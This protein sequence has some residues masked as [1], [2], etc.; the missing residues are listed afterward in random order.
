MFNFRL[1]ANVPVQTPALGRS[2]TS[3]QSAQKPWNDVDRR[4]STNHAVFAAY[5]HLSPESLRIEVAR[6]GEVA[7]KMCMF[8]DIVKRYEELATSLEL[9]ACRKE[10]E[11]QS[12]SQR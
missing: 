6:V 3:L 9:M 10:S 1:T 5:G 4:I 12:A 2:V 7:K 8:P 11:T